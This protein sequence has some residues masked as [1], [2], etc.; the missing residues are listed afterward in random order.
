MKP[1]EFRALLVEMVKAS[2]Q[3]LIDRAEDLVGN[4]DLLSEFA[5]WLNFP[6]DGGMLIG[7]PAIEVSKSY[8]S[9]KAHDV[10]L[11]KSTWQA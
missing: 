11:V 9:K 1:E 3:E 6:L 8:I 10:F 5:I 7:V 2:G 4:G